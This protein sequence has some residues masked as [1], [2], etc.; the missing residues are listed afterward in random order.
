MKMPNNMQME[1]IYVKTNSSLIMK[2]DELSSVPEASDMIQFWRSLPCNNFPGLRTFAQSF[3]CRFE[4][5][6][7]TTYI[8]E[9]AFS[10]MKRGSD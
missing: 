1:H 4:A 9:Q 10:A 3:I 2:F 6:Y 7:R 8:R 5:T